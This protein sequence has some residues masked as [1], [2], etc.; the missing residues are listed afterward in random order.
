MPGS[1]SRSIDVIAVMGIVRVKRV[2]TPTRRPRAMASSRTSM[3][4]RASMGHASETDR[5][6][7]KR[8]TAAMAVRP[9]AETPRPGSMASSQTAIQ[10][11]TAPVRTAVR[12]SPVDQRRGRVIRTP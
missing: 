5:A 8:P 12:M 4:R 3:T 9:S 2:R 6:A 10:T 1:G 11:A 7:K